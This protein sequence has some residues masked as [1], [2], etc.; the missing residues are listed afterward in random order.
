M[1][2][3][4]DMFCFHL[5]RGSRLKVSSAKIALQTLFFQES[6]VTV[7]RSHELKNCSQKPRGRETSSIFCVQL[8]PSSWSQIGWVSQVPYSPYRKEIELYIPFARKTNKQK[9]NKFSD[10]LYQP[11][12][13]TIL[14][15]NTFLPSL[16]FYSAQ[17]VAEAEG[18]KWCIS[19]EIKRQICGWVLRLWGWSTI[20]STTTT[21]M[22]CNQLAP[23]RSLCCIQRENPN[24]FLQSQ[25]KDSV[26]LEPKAALFPQQFYSRR[27]EK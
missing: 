24:Q 26:L 5:Q 2:Y 11:F 27:V 18:C 7:S 12:K 16:P 19:Q 10:F 22:P 8:I 3:P 23:N 1:L 21:G 17:R 6:K 4:S 13:E 25:T 15:K 14:S 20:Q 9:I